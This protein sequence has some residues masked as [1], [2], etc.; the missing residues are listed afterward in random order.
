MAKPAKAP[1]KI[2]TKEKEKVAHNSWG[3]WTER[4]RRSDIVLC[5]CGN[6]YIK[7]RKG[8]SVCV[9]CLFRQ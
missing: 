4:P 9:Q 7:T 2:D 3:S 6:R 1:K 8:Q 5:A